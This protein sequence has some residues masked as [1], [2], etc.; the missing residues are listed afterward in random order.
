MGIRSTTLLF[1]IMFLL[2]LPAASLASQDQSTIQNL[3]FTKE[4]RPNGRHRQSLLRQPVTHILLTWEEQEWHSRM[5]S[6]TVNE[7]DSAMSI[8]YVCRFKQQ[9]YKKPGLDNTEFYIGTIQVS[10]SSTKDQGESLIKVTAIEHTSPGGKCGK[11]LIR[12]IEEKAEQKAV[13]E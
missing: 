8:E 9:F 3:L 12:H 7:T 6:F 2:A 11:S 5:R 1:L 13:S 4:E 10:Y